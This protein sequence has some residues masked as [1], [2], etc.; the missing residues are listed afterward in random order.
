MGLTFPKRSFG[1]KNPVLRS[2]QAAWFK[3]RPFLHY[4]E[5]K[6]LSYYH[7]CVKG[8]KERKMKSRKILSFSAHFIKMTSIQSYYKCQRS[9]G[10]RQGRY[11]VDPFC[12]DVPCVL[13]E[14]ACM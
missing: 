4:D 1:E 12:R 14:N 3:T 2:F 7:I 13:V 8:F 11:G 5:G 9:G 10:A 6:D